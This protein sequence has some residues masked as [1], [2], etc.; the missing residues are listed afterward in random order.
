MK[1]TLNEEISRIKNLNNQ[2]S[3]VNEQLEAAVGVPKLIQKLLPNVTSVINLLTNVANQMVKKIQENPTSPT[4]FSDMKQIM[5]NGFTQ[6]PTVKTNF[7]KYIGIVFNK[8]GEIRDVFLPVINPFKAEMG[9][10]NVIP[11]EGIE[12]AKSAIKEAY[13]DESVQKYLNVFNKITTKLGMNTTSS[14][15]QLDPS[16]GLPNSFTAE[17]MEDYKNVTGIDLMTGPPSPSNDT[18]ETQTS[19]VTESSNS[20]KRVVIEG[21]DYK[22]V[23]ADANNGNIRFNKNGQIYTYELEAEK[24]PTNISINVNNLIKDNGI[25]KMEY[26]YVFGKGVDELGTNNLNYIVSQIPKEEIQF[27]NKKGQVLILTKV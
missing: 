12:V 14:M 24:F 27:T 25:L 5:V 10:Y 13:G 23:Y 11:K 4:I 8:Q 16:L 17:Q 15:T 20:N 1:K 18:G 21:I 26:S 6:N 3:N 7:D 9:E 22:G 19:Q 2:I